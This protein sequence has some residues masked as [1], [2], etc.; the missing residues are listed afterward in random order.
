MAP[1]LLAF[2]RNMPLPRFK[3]PF[4]RFLF[5][6]IFLF[7]LSLHS[8]P[9]WR[10]FDSRL[11]AFPCRS[12]SYQ[13]SKRRKWIVNRLFLGTA[14]PLAHDF[15]RS[16]FVKPS[17]IVRKTIEFHPPSKRFSYYP[18]FPSSTLLLASHSLSVTLFICASD[19][20]PTPDI[21]N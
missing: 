11:L 5:S 7:P 15:L 3:E 18:I 13:P 14:I 10:T 16:F 19:E 20:D 21:R 4:G 6:P 2:P 12:L 1:H 9:P 8:Y 17:R